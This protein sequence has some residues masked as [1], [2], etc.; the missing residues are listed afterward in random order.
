MIRTLIFLTAL[1]T[2]GPALAEV[3]TVVRLTVERGAILAASDLASHDMPGADIRTA[4]ASRDIV[5]KQAIRRLEPG[6]I[7]RAS[8]VRDPLM[9]EKNTAV[10][11]VVENGGLSIQA[12]G[13]AMQGGRKGEVIR[14]QT[15]GSNA[16]LE[17]E[18]V[19]AGRV[20]IA[21]GTTVQTAA[22]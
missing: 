6:R 13:R 14:V 1:L 3:V 8:D 17:G 18:I 12:A 5:G 7:I 20:R 4:L 16:N 19:A 2:A 15:L 9:I 11:L 22:R 10:T 21:V